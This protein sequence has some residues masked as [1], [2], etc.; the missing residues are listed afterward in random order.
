MKIKAILLTF[1]L[2]GGY[3]SIAQVEIKTE[4]KEFQLGDGLRFNVNDGEY[5]FR[6]GGFVQAFYQ[7]DKTDFQ[8]ANNF[9]NARNAFLTLSGSMLKEKVSF[10]LQNNFINGQPLLDAWVAYQPVSSLKITFGQKQTFTNDRENTF[11]EDK[12]QFVD[13]GLFSSKLSNSGREFGVFIESQFQKGS[14]IFRPKIAITSGDGLNSF[15]TNSADIDRGGLKYGGRIDL[16]PLGDFKEGNDGYIADLKHE[17]KLKI[18]TGTAFSYN[19]GASNEVGEGHNDFTFYDNNGAEKL[20]DF[21][22][23]YQDILLKYKGFSLLGEYFLSTATTLNGSFLDAAATRP[24]YITE[25]SEYL[26][27]G[28]GYIVRGGYV[29]KSGYAL[30]LKFETFNQ[31]FDNDAALLRD[32][33]NYTVGFTK[34]FK[35]NNLKLQTAVSSNAVNQFNTALNTIEKINTVTVQFAVQVAF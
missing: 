20:P 30:D 33:T 13:R 27:L 9:M 6:I 21:R 32:Q 3:N 11:F 25:I 12:L 23:L 18:L 28:N 2:F 34:Y 35:G 10:L 1:L 4:G 22:K 14:F 26:V 7:H 29:T 19:V 16:L 8:D 15:G 5:K 17:D 31:E 24:L